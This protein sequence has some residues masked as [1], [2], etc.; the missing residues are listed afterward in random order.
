M[1]QSGRVAIPVKIQALKN[2]IRVSLKVLDM[3]IKESLKVK[4]TSNYPEQKVLSEAEL[5]AHLERHYSGNPAARIYV[6]PRCYIIP[7]YFEY[8]LQGML[9]SFVDKEEYE[10][11]SRVYA[12]I[13]CIQERRLP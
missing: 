3:N 10:L 4:K 12:L 13:Q 7:A 1:N 11:C 8:A 9:K 5:L 6:A 2:S